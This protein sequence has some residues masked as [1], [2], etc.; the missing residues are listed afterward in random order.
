M[1]LD[2]GR[3]V[4]VVRPGQQIAFPMARHRL[5]LNRGRPLTN[6]DDILDMPPPIA[7]R[8]NRLGATHR[9]LRSKMTKQLF[10][11]HPAGLNK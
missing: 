5:I 8:V 9:A 1:T 3:D 7:I 4:A 2:Q 6:R 11:E 10:L